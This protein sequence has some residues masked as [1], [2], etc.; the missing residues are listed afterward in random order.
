MKIPLYVLSA[1]LLMAASGVST[2]VADDGQRCEHRGLLDAMQRLAAQ[3]APAEATYRFE[4]SEDRATI[5]HRQTGEVLL[6]AD[7]GGAEL[8]AA[9][10]LLRRAG[11][12]KA[13]PAVDATPERVLARTERGAT[14][15]DLEPGA[16]LPQRVHMLRFDD[17]SFSLSV[18]VEDAEGP[19]A[20]VL[21]ALSLNALG[22][23][24]ERVDA[25]IGCGC[26]RW[27]TAEGA[28]GQRPLDLK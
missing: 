20:R 19:R 6:L 22:D 24:V 1:T 13:G 18:G 23:L 17:G 21:Y 7:C 15:V 27:V 12:L 2:A 28:R 16:L 14:S 25:R 3:P 5:V 4:A 9:G 26:E 11:G 10:P 8:P